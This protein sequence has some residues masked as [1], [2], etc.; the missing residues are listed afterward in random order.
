MSEVGEIMARFLAVT[1]V[2]VILFEVGRVV[3]L[4]SMEEKRRLE[5]N[6]AIEK[7]RL[8]TLKAIRNAIHNDQPKLA[9]D[10]VRDAKKEFST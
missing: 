4:R 8:A 3:W 9:D 2:I 6:R 5:T 1:F 10:L 7:V